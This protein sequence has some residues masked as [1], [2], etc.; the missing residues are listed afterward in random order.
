MRRRAFLGLLLAAPT[1]A[2]VG[3]PVV[4]PAWARP[5]PVAAAVHRLPLRG[6][7]RTAA[8]ALRLSATGSR[9]PLHLTGQTAT[10]PFSLLGVTWLPDP[11]VEVRVQV[12]TRTG[13]RW[14][15]WTPLAPQGDHRPDGGTDAHPD[16]REGTAPH[17][18]GPS[19]GVQ[20][21]VDAVGGR[22]PRD[23]RV[24][25]V[26]P[27]SSP[28]DGR[29][30]PRSRA[31]AEEPRPPI[32]TRAQWGADESIRR[33]TPSYNSTVQVGFVHHT[34]GSNAYT[35]EQAAAVVR[36]VYAYHVKSNGWA[37]IGYNYLV[38]RFGRAYEGRAG[39]LDRFV[40]GSHTG[41]FNRDSFAVSLLGDFTSVPPSEDTLGALSVVLAWKLGAAYRDPLAKAV[42]TSAGGGTSRFA[43]G[44]P[45][46]FSVISGHRDAGNTSCPGSTT[47][48]RMAGI[49]SRVA[50][51]LGAGFADVAVTGGTEHP[52]GATARVTVTARTL[53]ALE[54][55]GTVTDGAGTV[56]RAVSGSNPGSGP[57]ELTWDL[58]DVAG[59]PVEPGRYALELAGTREGD[60]ALPHRTV[61]TVKGDPCRGTPLQRATCKITRRGG[62]VAG[63]PAPAPSP[64]A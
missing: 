19:D 48:A 30:E 2:A 39:G 5:R 40:V 24:E 25:L 4:T 8:G 63:P 59:R 21:R 3:L 46:T 6:V 27:G 31:F 14:T 9:A 33:G 7:D 20:V 52:R 53:G 34:A 43:A 57:A 16:L 10:R 47:Y 56:L 15:D 58:T 23:V 60:R 11:G 61:V 26:D 35:R 32:I 54:W 36:G 38:D 44:T 17:W 49:R 28:A 64:S 13:G 51:R 1:A 12:R 29:Q 41:G 37:D 42:L 55:T 50:E 18:V 62:T 45:V 22:R